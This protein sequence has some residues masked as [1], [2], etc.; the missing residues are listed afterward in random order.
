MLIRKA[1]KA[2][3][4]VRLIWAADDDDRASDTVKNGDKKSYKWVIKISKKR[5]S[6]MVKIKY[7]WYLI[8]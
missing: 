6:C 2:F 5:V 3:A 7:I 4:C 1:W 8:N